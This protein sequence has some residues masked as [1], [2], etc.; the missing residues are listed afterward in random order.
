[1]TGHQDPHQ[2]RHLPAA[3][4]FPRAVSKL[5]G[6]VSGF[7]VS[8]LG[9]DSVEVRYSSITMGISNSYRYVQLAKYV[10]PLLVAGYRVET[11]RDLPRL[12]VTAKTEA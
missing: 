1:M 12:I 9:A 8:K 6:G 3:A 10:T 2:A 5:R 11:A 4:E 7:S